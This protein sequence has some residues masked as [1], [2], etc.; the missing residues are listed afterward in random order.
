MAVATGVLTVIWRRRHPCNLQLYG[1]VREEYEG[2]AVYLPADEWIVMAEGEEPE[3]VVAASPEAAI[4][5]Y[6]RGYRNPT[7]ELITVA[8]TVG[9]VYMDEYGEIGVRDEY[10]RTV[11]IEPERYG[12]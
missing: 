5:E 3:V 9:R 12:G 2:R 1:F 10:R 4:E 8:V 11:E 7:G 6:V